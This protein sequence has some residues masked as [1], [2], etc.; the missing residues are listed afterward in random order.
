[1]EENVAIALAALSRVT[2]VRDDEGQLIGH[3]EE[4]ENGRF[5]AHNLR[6]H[7]LGNTT[8]HLATAIKK[9]KT[10]ELTTPD[11]YVH[12]KLLKNSEPAPVEVYHWVEVPNT[13]ETNVG[14]VVKTP[15]GRFVAYSYL[16]EKLGNTT[17]HIDTALA[18][19]NE[20]YKE[21]AQTGFAE[22]G[23]KIRVSGGQG[24][25]ALELHTETWT[26]L[27]A[28]SKVIS[29]RHEEIAD[30]MKAVRDNFIKETNAISN[31][32]LSD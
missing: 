29:H 2:T 8:K 12:K 26:A 3:V 15:K 23:D 1:M 22:Y 10:G 19:I 30:A 25:V 6:G 9:V 5:A 11:T 24:F 7:K 16:N 18:K 4:L 27:D 14:Y 17:K 13:S 21:L 32:T 20:R 28:E 31:S